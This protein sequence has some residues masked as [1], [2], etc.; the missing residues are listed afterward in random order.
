[1]VPYKIFPDSYSSMASARLDQVLT[2]KLR[3][4][5]L[6]LRANPAEAKDLKSKY[7]KEVF[8]TVSIALGSPP[9]PT[10]QFVWEYYDKDNKY[11]R[12]EGT[13]REYYDQFCKRKYMDPKDSFSLINDP[14]NKYEKLYTVE[15]LGNVVGGRSVQC[16]LLCLPRIL[17]LTIRCQC[18]Y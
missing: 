3:E 16:M 10:E 7:V 15:R 14:R 9:M 5:S 13:P 4:Y 2:S 1:M 18:D 8:N 6:H 12:W 11:H 17:W